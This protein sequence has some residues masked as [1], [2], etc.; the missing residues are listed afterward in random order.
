[1]QPL[2]NYTTSRDAIIPVIEKLKNDRQR[3]SNPGDY[4]TW[5][6]SG[7]LL[8]LL[9]IQL[10]DNGSPLKAPFDVAWQIVTATPRQLCT[11]LLK[12]T[13]KWKE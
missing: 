7:D 6:F 2:P 12:A 10:Y 4:P 5:C 8:E 9:D 1:M 11:A 3:S 13:G